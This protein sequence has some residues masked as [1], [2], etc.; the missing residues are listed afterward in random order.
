MRGVVPVARHRRTG[1]VSVRGRGS[2]RSAARDA[3]L[4]GTPPTRSPASSGD[5][6]VSGR[7]GFTPLID[8]R[9][10]TEVC[11]NGANGVD[12]VKLSHQDVHGVL[13][14]NGGQSDRNRRGQTRDRVAGGR[15]SRAPA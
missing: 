3:S 15:R 6:R 11:P 8:D 7:L 2:L 4:G 9:D 1:D 12:A 10:V 5:M 14:L 13:L